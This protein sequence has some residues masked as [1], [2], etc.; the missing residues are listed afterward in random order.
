MASND[1]TMKIGFRDV[2]T[3]ETGEYEALRKAS[4]WDGQVA[5]GIDP[6]RNLDL[7]PA[8][9]SDESRNPQSR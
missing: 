4:V 9:D 7:W 2:D 3:G 5:A 6:N 8:K 1:E